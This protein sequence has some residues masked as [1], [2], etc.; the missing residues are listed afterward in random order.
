MEIDGMEFLDWL[1][2]IRRESAAERKRRGISGVEW[3]KQVEE[4]AAA[5]EKE[6]AELAAP[7]ARDKP[8]SGD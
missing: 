5:V 8:K 7:I 4:R 2:R 6:I 3:L 1:H